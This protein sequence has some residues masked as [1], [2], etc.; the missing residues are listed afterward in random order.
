MNRAGQAEYQLIRSSRKTVAIQ[1]TRQGEVIVRAPRR[2]PQSFID[3]FVVEKQPWITG[4]QQ[5]MKR[6]EAERERLWGPGPAGKEETA[7]AAEAADEQVQASSRRQEEEQ[8]Y[9]AQAAEIFARKTAYYAARMGVTY[10]RITIRDQ[11]T[12]WGSC[13]AKGNLN[14]NWRLVLAPV[15]VLDYVI[16]HEL[17]HRR[18][19]NHSSRFWNIVGEAMPDYQT[20]RRWLRDHGDSL[21]G[22]FDG[23][24]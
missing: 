6:R 2:C 13:S 24:V 5:E 9:R 22:W 21:M 7:E 8:V 20:H 16:I 15:A 12:R 19:M 1:I 3:A 23:L 14:F 4:K 17:A 10:N 11:K 18:E